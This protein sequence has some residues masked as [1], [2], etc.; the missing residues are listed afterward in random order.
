MAK[1]TELQTRVLMGFGVVVVSGLTL[2]AIK[3]VLE[4]EAVPSEHSVSIE[5]TSGGRTEPAS[6]FYVLDKPTVMTVT[7]IA[8]AGYVFKGWYLN[9]EFAGDKTTLSF[10]VEGQNLLIAS[11]EEIGAPPLIPAYV[12]PVQNCVATDWWDVDTTT[13]LLTHTLH[14]YHDLFSDG[15]VK[16]KICDAAGNGVPDQL[17]AMYTD[18]MPDVTDYGELLIGKRLYPTTAGSPLIYMTDDEGIVSMP[19]RYRWNE[20]NSDYRYTIGQGGKVQQVC[21][22]FIYS[23]IYPIHDGHYI[24]KPCAY[25]KFTRV[26]NPIYRTLNPVHA[27]WVDNPGLAV[28]GDAFADCLV[29]LMP[30]HDL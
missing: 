26:K 1:L 29:K 14:L 24:L 5:S 7:A 16:F 10:T 15:F 8:F 2:A 4:V 21:F 6:G 13:E 19:C 23:D 9:G 25:T 30:S 3:A 11:F 20:P 17:I 18:P 28:W 12:R 22:P 27:Y